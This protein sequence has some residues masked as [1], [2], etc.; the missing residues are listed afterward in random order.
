MSRV[1][2]HNSAVTLKD[3]R[4]VSVIGSGSFGVVRLVTDVRSGMRYALK[5]TKKVNGTLPPELVY[6]CGL[7]AEID[8]PFMVYL[9][10]TLETAR[11]VYMLTELITGGDLF[12]AIDTISDGGVDLDVGRFYIGSVILALE[13]L[14]ARDIV[15]RDLKPQ[16]IMLDHHGY[17]KVIDFGTA[18]K[19]NG[20]QTFTAIGTPFYIAPELLR[21]R[22]YGKEPDLWSLG[23]LTYELLCDSYPFGDGCN[24]VNKIYIAVLNANLKFPQRMQ[25][26]A[27][28]ELIQ[29]LLEVDPS[30]RLGT[31]MRGWEEIRE[32]EFFESGAA[33]GQSLFDRLQ[34][35]ELE[36]PFVPEGAEAD[37]VGKVYELP[38]KSMAAIEAALSDAEEL[39]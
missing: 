31:G 24:D 14:H 1:L 6:E 5:R 20:S 17:I 22:A 9:V 39:A 21:G 12:C 18:K 27:S 2:L 8:H 25:D 36:A 16:N 38:G 33:N 3:L 4:H 26:S 32:C 7:L 30:E 19:L 34:S 28:K 11:H 37:S 23:V 29:G 15:Y 10:K 35:R 13:A